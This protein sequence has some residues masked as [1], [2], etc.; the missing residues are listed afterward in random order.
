MQTDYCIKRP[1][2]WGSRWRD[3]NYPQIKTGD[4]HT[5]KIVLWMLETVLN[6]KEIL[7]YFPDTTKSIII[8][9]YHELNKLADLKLRSHGTKITFLTEDEIKKQ[10]IDEY[11]IPQE[12]RLGTVTGKVQLQIMPEFSH[13][14]LEFFEKRNGQWTHLKR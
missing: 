1:D 12:V 14:L 3:I 9:D 4:N 10:G 8:Q 11:L 13:S 7:E 5:E 6:G 2:D